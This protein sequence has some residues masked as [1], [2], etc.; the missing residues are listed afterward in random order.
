M[1]LYSSAI[2]VECLLYSLTISIAHGTTWKFVKINGSDI[3]LRELSQERPIGLAVLV[4]DIGLR[5]LDGSQ[6]AKLPYIIF[7]YFT[8]DSRLVQRF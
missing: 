3:D 1:M 7:S 2:H 5:Q 4:S 8:R 6:F